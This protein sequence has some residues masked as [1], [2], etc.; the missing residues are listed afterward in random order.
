MMKLL[1]LPVKLIAL[2]IMLML[3]LLSL[4]GKLLT[5]VSAY[6]VG[7]FMLVVFLIGL[8]CLWE[9]RW[10]DLAIMAAIEAVTFA[11][12]FGAMLLAEFAGEWSQALREFIFS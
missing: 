3:F 5:N 4:L 7:L 2:P 9:H 6:I 1:L 8:Y 10:T 12:Q 11:L